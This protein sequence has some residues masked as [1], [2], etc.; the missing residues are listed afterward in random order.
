MKVL[1][2]EPGK[3]PRKADINHTLEN[4]QSIVG[5]YIEVTY[6]WQNRIGLICNEEGCSENCLSTG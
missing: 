4:L 6:Q 5:G 3:H 1:I 2:V